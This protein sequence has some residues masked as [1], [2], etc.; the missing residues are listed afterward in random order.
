MSWP[1]DAFLRISDFYP[2]FLTLYFIYILDKCILWMAAMARGGWGAF[3]GAGGR[4]AGPSSH[5]ALKSVFL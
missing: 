5:S 3:V 4:V 2:P 1:H